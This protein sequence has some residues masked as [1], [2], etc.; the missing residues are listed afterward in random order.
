MTSK[1]L[2][3]IGLEMERLDR[4]CEETDRAVEVW[5]A[6][7][8]LHKL[9]AEAAVARARNVCRRLERAYR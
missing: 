5:R 6:E 7:V 1:E 9:Q 2:Q 8:V 3:E 4:E